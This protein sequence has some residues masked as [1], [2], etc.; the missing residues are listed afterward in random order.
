[1]KC[2]RCGNDA[3]YKDRS[4]ERC[5]KCRKPFAFEPQKGD[6]FT[7]QAFQNALDRVSAK[8]QVRFTLRNLFYELDRAKKP[9]ATGWFVGSGVTA[10][11]GALASIGDAIPGLFFLT[12]SLV[13]G[14]TG[15][16]KSVR[17]RRVGLTQQEFEVAYAKWT[18]THGQPEALHVP[19]DD[20]PRGPSE[21]L[22][23]ELAHYS[24]DRAVI[25]DR[26]D[27]AELL[28]ANNFH[29][30]NN[31]A[32]LSFDGHPAQ[33]FDIVREMLRNNPRIEVFALHDCTFVGCALAWRLR[34]DARWFKDIGKVYDVALRPAQAEKLRGA[35]LPAKDATR[36]EHPALSPAEKSFLSRHTVELAAIRP[37]QLIKRLF[38]AM[39][40]LP[41]GGT[42]S[43]GDS[44]TGGDTYVFYDGGST[45]SGSDSS[46]SDFSSDATTSD[47]GADAFG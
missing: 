27:T 40:Q 19:K 9:M 17:R 24:F 21:A 1:M 32:V 43:T 29:F 25:T 2:I 11:I 41:Q 45:G 46:G 3:K 37:E 31:C 38:R 8:G 16:A 4:D 42:T 39:T 36:H 15:L 6:P 20:R 22:R 23:A 5:P 10:A 44:S 13:T 7:D 14:L 12:V 35:R 30:E 47:G 34:E 33:A 28:L 18:A 26:R